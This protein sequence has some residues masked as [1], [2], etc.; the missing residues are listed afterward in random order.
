MYYRILIGRYSW[1]EEIWYNEPMKRFPRTILAYL[2][3]LVLMV[4]VFVLRFRTLP[5]EIPLLYSLPDS[6]NQ[7]VDAWLIG[8]V[9]IISFVFIFI[10]NYVATKWFREN[11][12]VRQIIYFANMFIII[13]FTYIFIKILF[14]VS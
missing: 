14:L 13:S 12:F 9:P 10:N 2:V 5:T 6:D 7:I 3:S 1:I 4:I 11:Y 8:V